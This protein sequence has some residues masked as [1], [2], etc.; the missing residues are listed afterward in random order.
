MKK[1]QISLERS[2][3]LK[4]E[5]QSAITEDNHLEQMDVDIDRYHRHV[6]SGIKVAQ[7]IFKYFVSTP[8]KG[9]QPISFMNNI[10][11]VIQS[12][13][14]V[15]GVESWYPIGLISIDRSKMTYS[16]NLASL[17]LISKLVG[18]DFS[19]ESLMFMEDSEGKVFL[20]REI[21]ASW[22]GYYHPEYEENYQVFHSDLLLSPYLSAIPTARYTDVTSS[23]ARNPGSKVFQEWLNILDS[24]YEESSYGPYRP[25]AWLERE[26][27]R[28][29]DDRGSVSTNL[30]LMIDETLRKNEIQ[31]TLL[32]LLVTPDMVFEQI[33]YSSFEH[34]DRDE[35]LRL[36]NYFKN[37]LDSIRAQF[38]YR[39]KHSDQ[40]LFSDSFATNNLARELSYHLHELG[41]IETKSGLLRYTDQYKLIQHQVVINAFKLN[42]PQLARLIEEIDF[43]F[44]REE[45]KKRDLDLFTR[46]VHKEM[47]RFVDL[48][49]E[50]ASKFLNRSVKAEKR[51]EVNTQLKYFVTMMEQVI[52]TNL[53]TDSADILNLGNIKFTVARALLSACRDHHASF[54]GE[55]LAYWIVRNA[56]ILNEESFNQLL[57]DDI[58][59]IENSYTWKLFNRFNN[60]ADVL[61]INPHFSIPLTLIDCAILQGKKELYGMINALS[62][63]NPRIASEEIINFFYEEAVNCLRYNHLDKLDF[64]LLTNYGLIL[65]SLLEGKKLLIDVAFELKNQKG[66]E[67]I[68]D[69]ERFYQIHPDT[70]ESE[71]G[72]KPKLPSPKSN[73]PAILMSTE[74]PINLAS[75]QKKDN[76]RFDLL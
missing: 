67:L 59:L 46:Y 41:N 5:Y 74:G 44:D 51:F 48:I 72:I 14:T 2:D 24:Y 34:Q 60:L 71:Y 26:F 17:G 13:R 64:L 4:S 7:Q 11:S 8:E 33:F 47:N 32:R 16:S 37:R 31:K 70:R 38:N 18:A 43:N 57:K 66:F 65:C 6:T 68:R 20:A 53:R 58:S 54:F 45:N 19:H 21:E 1:T 76:L 63:Y 56:I 30:Y 55:T 75:P 62:H 10:S 39:K 27:D 25:A 12:H 23:L 9:S 49:E 28:K 22:T 69:Y 42:I 36:F 50:Q 61:I 3:S 73:N 52:R 40:D 35:A 15:F 29:S